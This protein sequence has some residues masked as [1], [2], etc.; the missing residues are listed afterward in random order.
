[1]IDKQDLLAQ[2]KHFGRIFLDFLCEHPDF[3]NGRGGIKNSLAMEL[4]TIG[5]AEGLT[6]KDTLSV[7][8]VRHWRDGKHKIPFWVNHAALQ[9]AS[10][11][12]FTVQHIADAVAVISTVLVNYTDEKTVSVPGLVIFVEQRY[13]LPIPDEFEPILTAF[14]IERG[15]QCR[16]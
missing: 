3:A 7:A 12:G 6:E 4:L 8:N 1:M 11:H 9:L 13:H 16:D 14:L 10:E 15:Y 2:G 5:Q